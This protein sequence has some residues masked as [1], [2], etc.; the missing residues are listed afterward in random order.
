MTYVSQ[1]R[2]HDPAYEANLLLQ[3]TYQLNDVIYRSFVISAGVMHGSICQLMRYC[4]HA[5]GFCDPWQRDKTIDVYEKYALR[6]HLLSD[7]VL[8]GSLAE[9]KLVFGT[10]KGRTLDEFWKQDLRERE[11]VFSQARSPEYR[12]Y[13]EMF[14]LEA[15][16][17]TSAD[18]VSRK[19]ACPKVDCL[20]TAPIHNMKT[21]QL[22]A[23]SSYA[24]QSTRAEHHRLRG[25]AIS[26][27]SGT[28]ALQS[29]VR[30]NRKKQF[31]AMVKRSKA[32][33]SDWVED[34]KSDESFLG[35][36]NEK[37][38]SIERRHEIILKAM[39]GRRDNV[40]QICNLHCRRAFIMSLFT[41]LAAYVSLCNEI[42]VL[43][44]W[45]CR[46]IYSPIMYSP[47]GFF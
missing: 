13:V 18:I 26:K 42:V 47:L 40:S 32:M 43:M 29:K 14:L 17:P 11:I 7:D 16:M 2:I 15:A 28:F 19:R 31:R 9:L 41:L 24:E 1:V 33:L 45:S 21:E 30:S 38:I 46:T 37:L 34:H 22:F 10:E 23:H 39:S 35:L 8:Y 27:A 3:N 20:K 12:P 44:R 4:W 5:E 25:L 6:L 36:F